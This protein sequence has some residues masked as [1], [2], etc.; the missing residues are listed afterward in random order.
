MRFRTILVSIIAISIAACGKA[1]S[2]QDDIHRARLEMQNGNREIARTLFQKGID[3][4]KKT[5]A[6][7]LQLAP[8][9]LE[10]SRV[11]LAL[12]NDTA[13]RTA[14]DAAIEAGQSGGGKNSEQL[15]PIYKESANQFYRKKQFVESQAAAKE[16]LRLERLCCEPGSLHLID[17]LNRVI[18][19]TCAQDR[20][21]D[22]APY[23]EEQLE[24]RRKHFGPTHSHVAVSLCLLAEV[25]EKKMKWK[26][27]E[28]KYLQ[29]LEI[30][31]KVE[32][33]LVSQTEKNL[34]R[35]R[36]HLN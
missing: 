17:S 23:L 33:Q 5:G 7:G 25:D 22:T 2:W 1:T 26:D 3:S 18:S 12:K 31:R 27:A 16:A 30:R 13:A 8:L 14:V 36:T 24:I 15:I 34:V 20:C 11:E 19:A 32:P 10:L 9:Y 4:G 29:A 28:S 21:A 6:N 35:V